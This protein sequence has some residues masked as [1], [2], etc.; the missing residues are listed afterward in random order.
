MRNYGATRGTAPA[1][2]DAT[3]PAFRTIRRVRARVPVVPEV[4]PQVHWRTVESWYPTIPHTS[5]PARRPA[6]MSA[7]EQQRPFATAQSALVLVGRRGPKKYEPHYIPRRR[8]RVPPGLPGGIRVVDGIHN[9][10]VPERQVLL[11]SD[12]HRFVRRDTSRPPRR[13]TS[14]EQ[15][16]LDRVYGQVGCTHAPGQRGGERRLA[17]AGQTGDHDEHNAYRAGWL[18]QDS[19]TGSAAIGCALSLWL[20][21]SGSLW[22]PQR[23]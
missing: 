16:V 3:P 23:T 6:P 18:R 15:S 17:D 19:A 5:A 12:A 21:P 11:G 4:V 8:R 1:E 13:E 20:C 22:R 14:T 10:G 9:N 7:P 2:S